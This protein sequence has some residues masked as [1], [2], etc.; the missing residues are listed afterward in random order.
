MKGTRRRWDF[1]SFSYSRF[2][3]DGQSRI[4]LNSLKSWVDRKVE[5]L[6]QRAMERENRALHDLIC[7]GASKIRASASCL[8]VAAAVK[9][10][11]Y[12]PADLLRIYYLE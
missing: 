8:A 4:D 9:M 3:Y 11:G 5:G 7:Y 10:K 12:Q 1:I 2:R 6:M